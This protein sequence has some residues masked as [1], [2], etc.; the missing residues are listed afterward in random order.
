MSNTTT[1]RQFFVSSLVNCFNSASDEDVIMLLFYGMSYP[2]LPHATPN[3]HPR[4]PSPKQVTEASFSSH[5]SSP[6]SATHLCTS[7]S[8]DLFELQ[9]L[10]PHMTRL[11]TDFNGR[12]LHTPSSPS[13]PLGEVG[14][15]T[16]ISTPTATSITSTRRTY[17]TS[18]SSIIPPP[19]TIPPPVPLVYQDQVLRSRI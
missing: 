9:P 6:T 8:T 11:P 12:Q 5:S 13:S 18:F 10:D 15:N 16:A 14:S 3:P 19:P 7:H 1:D 4:S 2:I 17:T